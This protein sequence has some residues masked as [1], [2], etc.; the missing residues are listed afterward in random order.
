MEKVLLPRGQFSLNM[1]KS[2]ATDHI[3]MQPQALSK[4]MVTKAVNTLSNVIRL[5]VDKSN[6]FQF[7]ILQLYD[8]C[9][10]IQNHK[11]F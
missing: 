7:D 3:L 6:T 10:Y 8:E 1:Q 11:V 9:I 4:T 2:L 5:K